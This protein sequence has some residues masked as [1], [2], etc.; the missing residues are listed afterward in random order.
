MRNYTNPDD[1]PIGTVRRL[2]KGY[3]DCVSPGGDPARHRTPK[4]RSRLRDIFEA[5]KS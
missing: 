5:R 2:A 3:W 4:F 1:P